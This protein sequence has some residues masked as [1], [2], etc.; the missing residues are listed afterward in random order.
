MF[1]SLFLCFI[2]P[3]LISEIVMLVFY[4]TDGT[5]HANRFGNDPKGR[6]LTIPT[7]DVVSTD[8]IA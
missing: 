5:P 2:L 6:G 1:G 8:G 7:Q 4:V 3:V